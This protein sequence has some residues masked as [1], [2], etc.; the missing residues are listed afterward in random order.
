VPSSPP[1]AD[2]GSDSE[3]GAASRTLPSSGLGLALARLEDVLLA[4]LLGTMVILAGGQIL[5]RNVFDA[6]MSWVDPFLRMLVLW[7]S[8]LGALVA[9]R[10]NRQISVDLVSRFTAPRWQ[11]WINVFIGLVTAG[12]T[13]LIAWYGA[14]FFLME[15]HDGLEVIPGFPS[16][17]PVLILPLAFGLIAVRYLLFAW[18]Q[19]RGRA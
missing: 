15:F 18:R 14:R 7:V 9:S 5:L 8:L 6:G 1:D 17:L 2:S 4:L 16:W 19:A 11:R 3:S 12:V 13:G 10:N